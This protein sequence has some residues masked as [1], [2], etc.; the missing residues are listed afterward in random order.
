VAASWCC[1]I[2]LYLDIFEFVVEVFDEIALY[3]VNVIIIVFYFLFA[4]W[5]LEMACESGL[6]LLLNFEEIFHLTFVFCK[7]EGPRVPKYFVVEK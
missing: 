2:W 6:S 7:V 1:R 3:I 4:I 5:A